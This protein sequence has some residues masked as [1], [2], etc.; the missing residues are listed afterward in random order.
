MKVLCFGSLNIDYTYRVKHFVEKGETL[1][2]DSLKVFCGGKGLNQ[3]IALARA[4]ADTYHA[5][6]VGTDGVFLLRQLESAGVNTKY[7]SVLE[8]EKTGH[9]IIQNDAE[10]DNCILLYGGANRGITK[11]QIDNVLGHFQEGDWL[12]LQNEINEMAYIME[13]GYRLGMKIAFTPAPIE[14][15]ILSYPLEYVNY[16]FLNRGE[17][18]R[19]LGLN[20]LTEVDEEALCLTLK[21]RFPSAEIILTLGEKGAVYISSKE[22]IRQPAYSVKAVDTTAAG[23]TFAGFFIG[24][25]IRK[26]PVSK[27]MELSARASAIGVTRHGASASIPTLA[28]TE[29]WKSL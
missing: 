20:T 15:K 23:D 10:G 17:A 22:I 19:I 2:A 1:S 9:A 27:A 8:K 28:E 3:S 14:K 29:A 5:G 26:M 24:G 13:M 12:V 18:V 11:E 16:L 4:G 25:L 7:V 6:A 21:K